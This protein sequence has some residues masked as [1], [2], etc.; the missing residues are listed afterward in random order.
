[1]MVGYGR[2]VPMDGQG[3]FAL[4]RYPPRLWVGFIVTESSMLGGGL[5]S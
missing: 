4:S 2:S 1:M 5:R 3:G